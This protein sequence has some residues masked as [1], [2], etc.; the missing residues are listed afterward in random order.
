[1]E[2]LDAVAQARLAWVKSLSD[3]E[4]ALLYG[5]KAAWANEETKGERIAEM[6]AT[7]QANDTNADGL[8]N[9]AEFDN[10]VKAM[11]QNAAA[12]GLPVEDYDSLSE[13]LKEKWYAVFAAYNTEANGVSMTSFDAAFKAISEKMATM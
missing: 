10:F 6:L 8:L 13:E 3:D 11:G 7:F 4:R 12:R 9:R 2:H 5:E 1:M